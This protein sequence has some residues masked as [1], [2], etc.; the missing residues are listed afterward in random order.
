LSK[1]SEKKRKDGRK[2]RNNML[3]NRKYND[4]REKRGNGR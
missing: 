4:R 1:K 2:G 3:E